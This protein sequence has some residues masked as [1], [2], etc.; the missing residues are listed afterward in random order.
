MAAP[1]KLSYL[2]EDCGTVTDAGGS[3]V[4][5]MHADPYYYMDGMTVCASCGEVPDSKCKLVGSGQNLAEYCADLKKTKG[6]PYHVIR[7]GILLVF[8]IVGA[9]AA[10]IGFAN[11]PHP[12][13]QPWSGLLGVV[14]GLFAS[15]FI[16]RWIRLMLCKAGVI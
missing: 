5:N 14:M 15:M 13:P 2:H 12:I 4:S 7:W 11:A 6:T 1:R 10:S 3:I 16:G 8:A 9:I